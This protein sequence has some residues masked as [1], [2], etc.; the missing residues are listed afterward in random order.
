M[1]FD[2]TVDIELRRNF[3]A[4][5]V[6]M[7]SI[8]VALAAEGLLA[9]LDGIDTLF[10]ISG[11]S[12]LIWTQGALVLVLAALF[13]W[14]TVRWAVS[15]PWRFGISDALGPL[16]LLV[17]VHFLV[18]AIGTGGGRWFGAQGLIAAGGSIIYLANARRAIALS[19]FPDAPSRTALLIPATIG[20]VSGMAALVAGAIDAGRSFS[21]TAH[22]VL[23]ALLAAG[24]VAFA[25][26]EHRIWRHFAD[27]APPS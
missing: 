13:W 3:P 1:R 2:N 17:A 23:N 6:T 14:V 18:T 4:V 10:E 7:L 9:K 21:M 27:R 5:Y 12:L 24:I 11:A 22:L 16:G 20:V 8:V 26:T 19:G 25:V 15:F